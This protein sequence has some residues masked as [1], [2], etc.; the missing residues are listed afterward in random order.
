MKYRPKQVTSLD[1]SSVVVP[2]YLWP[3]LFFWASPSRATRVVHRLRSRRVLRGSPSREVRRRLNPGDGCRPSSREVR[4]QR[5][6]QAVRRRPSREVRH[7]RSRQALCRRPS[8]G[9]RR[10][11]SQAGARRPSS[12]GVRRQRSRRAVRRHP[13]REV[14]HLLS[15]AGVRAK[16]APPAALKS[17]AGS[18]QHRRLAKMPSQ[19]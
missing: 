19:P 16:L 18:H 9:V 10:P 5:S 4:R 2:Y 6:R 1:L 17:R 8:R 11:R 7:L 3:G 15:R 14:R 13:S 12:R